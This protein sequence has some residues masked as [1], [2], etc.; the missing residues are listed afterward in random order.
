VNVRGHCSRSD[1]MKN[2]RQVVWVVASFAGK[3]RGNLHVES[4][5]NNE[6]VKEIR[7]RDGSRVRGKEN[8]IGGR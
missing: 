4:R 7:V 1:G 8:V 2:L 5:K 6:L 3:M